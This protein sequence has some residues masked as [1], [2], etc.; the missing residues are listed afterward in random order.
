MYRLELAKSIT[1]SWLDVNDTYTQ[2][3]LGSITFVDYESVM[4]LAW[5][6]FK[7]V[8]TKSFSMLWNQWNL[9]QNIVTGPCRSTAQSNLHPSLRTQVIEFISTIIR[10]GKR[11]MRRTFIGIIGYTV[12]NWSNY[13]FVINNRKY[14]LEKS[15]LRFELSRST[16]LYD[17]KTDEIP[18]TILF[19][20]GVTDERSRREN[21]DFERTSRT[22]T[23][24]CSMQSTRRLQI[25]V[26]HELFVEGYTSQKSVPKCCWA[27]LLHTLFSKVL[28]SGTSTIPKLADVGF[29]TYGSTFF[30]WLFPSEWYI[31][32]AMKS[33][34]IYF[35]R[36]IDNVF[37]DTIQWEQIEAMG[38]G[39]DIVPNNC[40]KTKS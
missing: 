5:L 28:P 14:P 20:N 35:V 34:A 25:N 36:P 38:T 16:N 30:A 40:N 13:G 27:F 19:N 10:N 24:T 8:G 17:K 12:L 15:M 7:L 23:S 2:K 18:R 26:H 39:R 31:R 11:R 21:F 37:C 29:V 4:V 33:G 32:R 6:Q 22:C 3:I 1:K 9:I